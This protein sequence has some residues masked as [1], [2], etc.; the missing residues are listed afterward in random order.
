MAIKAHADN[1]SGAVVRLSE[2]FRLSPSM[3]LERVAKVLKT[4]GGMSYINN[5]DILV[6]AYEKL[7]VDARDA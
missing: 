5:D 1:I 6:P 4:G 2:F 3:L 7:G